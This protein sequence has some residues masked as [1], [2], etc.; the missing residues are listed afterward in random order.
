MFMNEI[1]DAPAINDVTE[2][3]NFTIGF[4]SILIKEEGTKSLTC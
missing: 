4:Q 2:I 3:K 1:Q